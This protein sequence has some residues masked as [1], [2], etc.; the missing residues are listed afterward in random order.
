[1][2]KSTQSCSGNT[3]M[4]RG[5]GSL[6]KLV[7]AL[8]LLIT[9]GFITTVQHISNTMWPLLQGIEIYSLLI[10]YPKSVFTV[11]LLF[12]PPVFFCSAFFFF[13]FTSE[14]LGFLNRAAIKHK[15]DEVVK[16]LSVWICHLPPPSPV[17]PKSPWCHLHCQRRRSS[18]ARMQTKTLPTS[19]EYGC[20]KRS[21]LG[22][23]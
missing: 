20:A 19:L 14:D 10:T 6:Y 17:L 4:A 8:T 23:S 13:S 12:F 1:M 9:G 5:N 2:R 16:K 11:C 21:H 22:R 18:C 7:T 15:N 3:N